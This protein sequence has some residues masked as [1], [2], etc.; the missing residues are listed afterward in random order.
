MKMTE[1]KKRS[2]EVYT[3]ILTIV[4]AVGGLIGFLLSFT[5][6]YYSY[7]QMNSS[8]VLLFLLVGIGTALFH[9]FAVRKFERQIWIKF[10]TFAVTGLLAAAAVLLIGD[11][12]EG[13][14]NCIVTDFDSGHG[15]EEAIYYSLAGAAMMFAGMIT[16]IIGSFS[17]ERNLKNG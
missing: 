15:G 6:H 10:L 8:F 16:N 7:G 3:D 5:T 13:I 11:R 2:V 17:K 9:L 1:K 12:V 4:W 14:G